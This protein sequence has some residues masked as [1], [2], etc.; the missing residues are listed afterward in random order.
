MTGKS[1]QP[2][3]ASK[4]IAGAAR[5]VAGAGATF[6]SYDGIGLAELIRT[7]QVTAGEVVEDAIRQIEV[8]NPK[9]N[10]VIHKTY[11]RARR[12]AATVGECPFA[13]VPFLVKDNATI[14]GIQLT[15]GSRA[16]GGEVPDRTAPLFAAAEN[17]GLILLGVP[18]C[19]SWVCSTAPRTRCTGRPAI[20]G[21]PITPP[22]DRAAAR[23]PASPSVWCRWRTA[24]MAAARSAY[25]RRTAACSA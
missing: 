20:H 18:T 13:G 1:G 7:K 17:I 16:L 4:G 2:A 23:R 5:A 11:D 15:R 9:L 10:A 25:R 21:I 19:P 3:V 12:R 8:L 14:A 22:A 6:S 24:P